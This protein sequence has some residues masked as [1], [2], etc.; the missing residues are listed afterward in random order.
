MKKLCSINCLLF[1]LILP[2][3]GVTFAVAQQ[4]PASGVEESRPQEEALPDDQPS[5]QDLFRMSPALWSYAVTATD[6]AVSCDALPEARKRDCQKSVGKLEGFKS[7]AKGQCGEFNSASLPWNVCVAHKDKNCLS[8]EEPVKTMCQALNNTKAVNERVAMM[9]DVYEQLNAIVQSRDEKYRS[10]RLELRDVSLVD[11][12]EGFGVVAGCLEHDPDRRQNVCQM[13]FSAYGV[14]G[15]FKNQYFMCEILFGNDPVTA[16]LDINRDLMMY[17][18]AHI[19][20][21]K[22]GCDA[23]KHPDLRSACGQ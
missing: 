8:W 14:G 16:A 21:V 7:I 4:E 18:L 12:V 23:I 15:G 11:L 3:L 2:L 1:L 20:T 6:G 19:D 5:Q 22:N 13:F 10:V 9:Q 17:R